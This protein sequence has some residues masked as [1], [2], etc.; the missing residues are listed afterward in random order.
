MREADR[1]EKNRLLGEADAQLLVDRAVISAPVD[2]GALH[3]RSAVRGDQG[4]HAIL[5]GHEIVVVA[6]VGPEEYAEL[7][8][9]VG[10][11]RS[12]HRHQKVAGW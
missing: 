5:I 3:H 1:F 9:R 12:I 7:D 11:N 8:G 6:G 10:R 4:E 2:A